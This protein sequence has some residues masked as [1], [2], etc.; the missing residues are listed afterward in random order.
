[1]T[2]KSFSGRTDAEPV[3]LLVLHSCPIRGAPSRVTGLSPPD[4]RLEWLCPDGGMVAPRMSPLKLSSR[5]VDEEVES[6]IR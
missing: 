5:S 3:D 6:T 4:V 2:A 1:V